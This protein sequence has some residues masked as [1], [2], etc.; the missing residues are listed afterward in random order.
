[1]INIIVSSDPRYNI[2]KDSIRAAVAQ[3]LQ[4]HRISGKIEVGINIVGDRKMRS[5]NKNYK[6]MDKTTNILSFSLMDGKEVV[7]PPRKTKIQEDRLYLGDI[8]LAYPQVIRDAARDEMMVD[9]KINELL[10]HGLQHL[11]GIHH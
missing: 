7:L 2:N 11:L 6:G 3:I 4:R 10:E 5:L 1:M 8:V 9:D